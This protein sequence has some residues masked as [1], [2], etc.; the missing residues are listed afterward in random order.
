MRNHRNSSKGF[1]TL[2]IAGALAL[3]AGLT[4]ATAHA[5]TAGTPGT[6]PETKPAQAKIKEPV[7]SIGCRTAR[8]PGKPYFVE[9]RSR[10]AAS[11]GHTFVFHGTLGGGNRFASFKVA[12]LHPKGD[13]PGV[14]MQ[15]HLVPVPAETGVSYGDLDEQYL[16][17]RF[18][19]TLTEPE[20]RRAL[21][22]IQKL[23]RET[24]TWHAPTYNCNSFAAD[25]A[26]HIGLDTP[27]PNM[28]LPE[29]FIKRLAEDNT[30]KSPAGIFASNPFA[31]G[32]TDKTKPK[33]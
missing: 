29:T 9:F 7:T 19:V 3:A 2:G 11:Y 16:T 6:K 21:A 32:S 33:R 31:T 4:F 1:R 26:K 27:N 23:Q 28:Y 20:Y 5:Q 17:A 22:Y 15:G 10:T 14:Y 25:I 30:K 8:A 18:C 24:K 12:G 13:D